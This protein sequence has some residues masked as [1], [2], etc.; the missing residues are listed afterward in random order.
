MSYGGSEETRNRGV[1]TS[2]VPGMAKQSFKD[3][4]DINN[5][6]S[7]FMA[8][9]MTDHV[10]QNSPVYA[11]ISEMPDFRTALHQVK[12]VQEFFAGLPAKVRAEFKNDPAE[13]LD[14]MSDVDN[15]GQAIAAGLIPDPA[16]KPVEG[17]PA[18]V[19]A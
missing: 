12:Q 15:R 6:V 10:N 8:N 4:V 16:A 9:G 13:F 3:E 14:Y 7:R 18:V 1:D 17:A 5:I 2:V 11:D 19:P